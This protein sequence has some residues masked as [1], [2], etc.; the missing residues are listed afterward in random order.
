MDVAG[1]LDRGRLQLGGRRLQLGQ[2]RLGAADQPPARLRQVHPAAAPVEQRHAGLALE[3]RE[4]LGDGRRGEG[5]RA[6]CR[7]DRA[8]RGDLAQH[9]H[10]AHVERSE[11]CPPS[12]VQLTVWRRDRHLCC[13]RSVRPWPHAAARRRRPRHDDR[14]LGLRVP[15]DPRRAPALRRRAPERAA[16]AR[17][18]GGAR[19]RRRA[20]RRPAAGAARPARARRHRPGRHGRVPVAA[21]R[22]RG[23]RPGR[24]RGAA[25]QPL[26][27]VHRDR[28]ERV[29]RRGH[30]AGGGGRA[31][32]S[33]APGPA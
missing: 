21:Q 11:R 15:G 1:D 16:A 29:P 14:P 13:R 24:H 7:G 27:R 25:G 5:E 9:A 4:L 32:R 10:A 28:G 19:G 12:L 30:D 22:R 26:A 8:A 3:R 2:D 20:A 23:D 18:G 17:R 6:R 33:R 31:W